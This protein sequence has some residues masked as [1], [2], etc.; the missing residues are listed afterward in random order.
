VI[1]KVIEA[2][3]KPLFAKVE[4]AL[5]SLDRSQSGAQIEAANGFSIDPDAVAQHLALLDS[6]ADTMRQHG[7]Q[8]APN[9]AG[10]GF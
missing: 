6:H 5:P 10:L 4:Q 2:A 3:A 8:F 9:I 7:A 1:G